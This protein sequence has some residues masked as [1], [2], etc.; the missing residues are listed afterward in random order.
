MVNLLSTGNRGV[1]AAISGVA[2]GDDINRLSQIIASG[3]ERETYE[4]LAKIHAQTRC[5]FIVGAPP[6]L[7]IVFDLMLN[8]EVSP[9]TRLMA[10]LA[11]LDRAGHSTKTLHESE[12]IRNV[13]QNINEMSSTDISKALQDI[14]L[15]L[16]S[17]T[18]SSTN[19]GESQP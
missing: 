5:T 7:T 3:S 8:E 11:V 1:E 10:A 14:Q 9:Q 12:A 13:S 18:P 16:S 6:A 17:I 2:T 19:K 15:K 4:I